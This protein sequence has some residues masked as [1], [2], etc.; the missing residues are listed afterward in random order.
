MSILRDGQPL[1]N[2]LLELPSPDPSYSSSPSSA[3]TA[4]MGVSPVSSVP[5]PLT[6]RRPSFKASRLNYA[7]NMA[8]MSMMSNGSNHDA[9]G[10]HIVPNLPSTPDLPRST[11]P[12]HCLAKLQMMS[13]QQHQQ[14][15]PASPA[16]FPKLALQTQTSQL[17]FAPQ[18]YRMTNL[19]NLSGM[20]PSPYMGGIQRFTMPMHPSR[21]GAPLMANPMLF[22]ESPLAPLSSFISMNIPPSPQ[23]ALHPSLQLGMGI[24]APYYSPQAGYGGLEPTPQQ[25]D[26]AD[27]VDS[28]ICKYFLRGTCQKGP[29]C[30]FVHQATDNG[31]TAEQPTELTPEQIAAQ[32]LRLKKF[33]TQACK[34]FA[35]QGSCFKGEACP[36]I[37]TTTPELVFPLKPVK[38]KPCRFYAQGGGSRCRR[39]QSCTFIH[40]PSEALPLPEHLRATQDQGDEQAPEDKSN[41]ALPA[42]Q[43]P[44]PAAGGP[45]HDTTEMCSS[46]PCG[47]PAEAV[48]EAVHGRSRDRDGG[49]LPCEL[50]QTAYR[51]RACTRWSLLNLVSS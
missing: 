47:P 45:T 7:S 4:S 41:L 39:G 29:R 43:Q 42:E 17:G 14:Q 26:G 1:L 28:R 30:D 15:Q 32:E 21:G 5:S 38:T 18:P 34:F 2:S 27:L 35:G 33:K 16:Q 51:A 8:N 46:E 11:L 23:I 31:T 13:Q 49:C 37:H 20:S 12:F 3:Y 10:T 6:S 48:Q 44:D 19:P 22:P 36:Y 40:D 24:A 25:A 9:M 50:D